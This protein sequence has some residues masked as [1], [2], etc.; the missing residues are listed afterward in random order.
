MNQQSNITELWFAGA[1]SDI[2][3][4][5]YRDGLAD[6]CLRY[7]IEWLI[8][9]PFNITFLTSHDIDYAAL[10][11]NNKVIAQDDITITP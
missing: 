10:L 5:Y 4:G 1:H 6:I 7:A 11:P 8:S 2:G 3:G 9:Q